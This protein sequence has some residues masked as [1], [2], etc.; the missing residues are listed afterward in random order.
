MKVANSHLKCEGVAWVYPVMVRFCKALVFI[1]IFGSIHLSLLKGKIHKI[2][3]VSPS[4][5]QY[6]NASGLSDY[7]YLIVL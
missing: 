4:P 1:R 6:N 3:R 7:L 5:G 2:R